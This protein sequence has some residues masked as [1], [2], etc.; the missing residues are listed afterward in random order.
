MSNNKQQTAVKKITILLMLLVSLATANAQSFS[1]VKFAYSNKCNVYTFEMEGT[2]D[3]TC[4]R[5]TI[6]ITTINISR[7]RYL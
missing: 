3:T 5:Q 4:F 2:S 1:K 6:Y 7:H